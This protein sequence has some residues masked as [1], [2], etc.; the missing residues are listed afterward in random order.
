MLHK[1]LLLDLLILTGR[2]GGARWGLLPKQALEKR[3]VV[4]VG[5][6]ASA[7]VVVFPRGIE[8]VH[9]VQVGLVAFNVDRAT[10]PTG[11]LDGRL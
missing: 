11:N 4:N 5:D 10:A 7:L 2:P 9:M 6:V 3:A 1:L 8:R